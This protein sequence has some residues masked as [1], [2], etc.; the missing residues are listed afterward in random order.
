MTS[1]LPSHAPDGLRIV[2]RICDG[3]E[4]Q[5]KQGHRPVLAEF[6]QQLPESVRAEGLEELLQLDIAYRSGCGESPCVSDYTATFSDLESVVVQVF[7]AAAIRRARGPGGRKQ[8]PGGRK[9]A[10]TLS[11]EPVDWPMI[12][13]LTLLGR[14][15]SGGMG[16]V[17]RARDEILKRMVA[18]KVLRSGGDASPDSVMRLRREAESAARLSH[19]NIVPI[20]QVVEHLG[21]PCLVMPFVKGGTLREAISGRPQDVRETSRILHCLALAV[22]HAHDRGIIHRDL[23]PANVLLERLNDKED[24]FPSAAGPNNGPENAESGLPD[25]LKSDL[26]MWQP[27]ITDFGLARLLDAIDVERTQSGAI[28]GTPNYLSPEQASGRMSQV[29]QRTDIYA[30]GAILYEMLT[31]RP[32]HNETSLAETLDAIRTRDPVPPRRIH[33][34]IP[35]DLETICLRCLAREP[36]RRY[37]SAEMLAAD[38]DHF[39]HHRPIRA[40]RASPVE[41]LVRHLCRFP[42]ATALTGLLTIIVVASLSVTAFVW[43]RHRQD[44]DNQFQ[45]EL[46]AIARELRFLDREE[47][48]FVSLVDPVRRDSLR[49]LSA[50]CAALLARPH[51]P[52]ILRRQIIDVQLRLGTASEM[53]GE[54][55]EAEAAYRRALAVLGNDLSAAGDIEDAASVRISLGAFLQRTGKLADSET[56]LR[57]AVELT[58][59]ETVDVMRLQARALQTLAE[60]LL[61]TER[62]SESETLCERSI[63]LG[64]NLLAANP[65][66]SEAAMCLTVA[67]MTLADLLALFSRMQ[68]A[69]RQCDLAVRQIETLVKHASFPQ[70]QFLL[71]RVLATRAAVLETSGNTTASQED[72]VRRHQVLR[73]LADEY[74]KRPEYGVEAAMSLHDAGRLGVTLAEDQGYVPG[75]AD[76]PLEDRY[77]MA[78]AAQEEFAKA[79]PELPE[80]ER[81]LALIQNS[82]ATWLTDKAGYATSPE[83]RTSALLESEALHRSSESIWKELV[84]RFPVVWKYRFD[85]ARSHQRLGIT[86][87]RLGKQEET[88]SIYRQSIATLTPFSELHPD[89]ARVWFSLAGLQNNLGV[90]ADRRGDISAAELSFRE[91]IRLGRQGLQ[92]NMDHPTGRLLVSQ[93]TDNLVDVLM[94]T[95]RFAEA[96]PLVE[97]VHSLWTPGDWWNYPPLLARQQALAEAFRGDKGLSDEARSKALREIQDRTIAWMKAVLLR[98]QQTPAAVPDFLRGEPGLEHI[99]ER[100]EFRSLLDEADR[101]FGP[102]PAVP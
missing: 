72:L 3:F 53:A 41:K 61:L 66:D 7:D 87:Q 15:G 11:E 63:A 81:R 45:S 20:Y 58:S 76:V 90:L 77:R 13:G 67:R 42:R 94:R 59:G 80:N 49:E 95:E 91:A 1:K 9:Q 48:Q 46:V 86:L 26:S 28:L 51:A 97:E 21:L 29:D 71:A 74:P 2:D 54:F 38:L 34:Q 57:Q 73:T 25:R 47:F 37:A 65:Q 79:F 62:F 44:Q 12:S 82:L 14:A 16:I 93:F 55:A 96:V 35:K 40:R 39:L 89:I 84:M 88:E 32:P 50:Q 4:A 36:N 10:A 102:A 19:P 69:R 78:L 30:L 8:G 5:W 70:R 18:V 31:G 83:V 101:R 98:V 33:G 85:L 60:H 99:R 68:E 75:T 22:Q 64:E 17:Y 52:S 24:P 23:K 43:S 6:L 27:R 56:L 100:D 92:R